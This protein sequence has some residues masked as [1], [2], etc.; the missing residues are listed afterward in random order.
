M[1][2]VNLDMAILGNYDMH[3]TSYL[4]VWVRQSLTSLTIDY[5]PP[6]NFGMVQMVVVN[7]DIPILGNYE[8]H[9]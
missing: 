5:T 6:S 7:F 2:V 8:L 4:N 1:T 9:I 3:R